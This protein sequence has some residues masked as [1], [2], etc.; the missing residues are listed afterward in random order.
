M[1]GAD[2]GKRFGGNNCGP[3][4]NGDI[5]NPVIVIGAC[6]TGGL[7]VGCVVSGESNWRHVKKLHLDQFADHQRAIEAPIVLQ[8]LKPEGHLVHVAALD[9]LHRVARVGGVREIVSNMKAGLVLV[10][11]KSAGRVAADQ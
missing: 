1:P 7:H 11:G 3:K 10:E 8:G 9:E 5:F 4:Y 2:R 6:L